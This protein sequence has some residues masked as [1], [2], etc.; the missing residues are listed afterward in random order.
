MTCNFD[1]HVARVAAAVTDDRAAA[2]SR[3]VASWSRSMIRHNLDPGVRQRPDRLSQRQLSRLRD[4][5][6]P[7]LR[8]AEK[9]L[10]HLAGLMRL[11]GC[12]IV[13]ADA[14]GR[15]LQQ[16]CRDEDVDTF[17]SVNLVPGGDWNE[18][19][20]GTN[21][22]GTCVREERRLSIRREEHFSARNI[23]MTCLCAPVH[24][25]DGALAAV[26]DISSARSD[27]TD[28]LTGLLA[29]AVSQAAASIELAILQDAFPKARMVLAASEGVAGGYLAVDADDV[30]LGATRAARRQLGLSPTGA[31]TPLPLRDLLGQECGRTGLETAEYAALKRALLRA[32]GNASAAARALGI[33][34]ATLYRRMKRVGMGS[35]LG[36]LTRG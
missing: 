12:A 23:A 11:S 21:G 27:Q 2:T 34:R 18:A 19:V 26:V 13:L 32:E 15:I 4:A 31:V 25:V 14:Q 10:D 16:R 22:I 17:D 1:A 9:A 30:V 33:G 29:E 35:D 20:E 8:N 36:E 6:G 5:Q 24:G 7:V 3:L 28:G